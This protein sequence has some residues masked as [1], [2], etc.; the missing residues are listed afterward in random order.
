MGTPQ[1]SHTTNTCLYRNLSLIKSRARFVQYI[2]K[3]HKLL[4]S[5]WELILKSHYFIHA[6]SSPVRCFTIYIYSTLAWAGYIALIY[7]K[8]FSI[9]LPIS[10]YLVIGDMRWFIFL[11][12]WIYENYMYFFL[13]ILQVE[14]IQ[15]IKFSDLAQNGYV[16]WIQY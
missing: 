14:I 8:F 4:S 6:I 12:Y 15:R 1:Q 9:C 16:Y 7:P 2:Q 13:I 5:C 10:G 11:S 3:L